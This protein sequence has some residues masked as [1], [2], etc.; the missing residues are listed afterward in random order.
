M[1][2]CYVFFR[3]TLAGIVQS[4]QYGPFRGVTNQS[5]AVDFS[6]NQNRAYGSCDQND[7]LMTIYG[8]KIHVTPWEKNIRIH[9]K[10]PSGVVVGRMR[11]WAQ[12]FCPAQSREW[13]RRHMRRPPNYAPGPPHSYE[14]ISA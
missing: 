4:S 12:G 14:H 8:H 9:R 7:V 13:D 2:Q 1:S 6:T 5:A 11:S 3:Y 10:T